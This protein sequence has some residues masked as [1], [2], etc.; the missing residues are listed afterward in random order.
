[1]DP[2]SLYYLFK[3]G[4]KGLKML[5][6]WSAEDE[7]QPHSKHDSGKELKRLR[8]LSEAICED[9]QRLMD[10]SQQQQQC[11]Q[12]QQEQIDVLKRL[13]GGAFLMLLPL[14]VMVVYLATIHH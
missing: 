3:M 12:Q 5:Q 13:M 14:L 9:N 11:I 1:M 6:Q 10:A 8:E 7:A 2:V 4:G